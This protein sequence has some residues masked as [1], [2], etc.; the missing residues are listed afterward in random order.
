MAHTSPFVQ[1]SC[2][3]TFF[4]VIPSPRDDR[5][6]N[7]DMIFD[8][9]YKYPRYLDW[10]PYLQD[11]RN[12]GVQGSSLAQVGAC[13]LEW[14]ERKFNKNFVQLSPQFIYNGR[15]DGK[16]TLMCGRELMQILRNQGA[17]LEKSCTYGTLDPNTESMKT[18]AKQ[19][20]IHG[21]TRVQTME[22]LKVALSVFGPALITFPVYNHTAYMWKQHKDEQKLGGHA[23]AIVGYNSSGFI[24]RNSWGKYWE[25]Q[26]Y[27]IYPYSD[28]GYHEEVWC[29]GN[30]V[31]YQEW[32]KRPKGMLSKM[33]KSSSSKKIPREEA[34][35]TPSMVI[36]NVEM[37]KPR[38][39][40]A[41]SEK[42][43]KG[44]KDDDLSYENTFKDKSGVK[45]ETNEMAK[46]K[47]MFSSFFRSPS[48]KT[49]GEGETAAPAEG[50]SAPEEKKPS[51]EGE[52]PAS[53]D[54]VKAE[55][56]APA[57]E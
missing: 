20:A 31:A 46:K 39:K 18:D 32:L 33:L 50:E 2:Q 14:R 47:G 53:S 16:T 4:N 13:M 35:E 24:L 49:E 7:I 56:N 30:E 34:S 52:A 29:M 6:V 21:Y 51:E 37:P 27:C 43:T 48:S 40:V 19:Y 38:E 55:E 36:E 22:T 44:S 28:W 23:M 57:S 3:V 17:C 26:G 1:D 9:P 41:V 15:A 25:N 42:K 8:P 45:T 10:S 54:E 11:I 5:D 12:Q